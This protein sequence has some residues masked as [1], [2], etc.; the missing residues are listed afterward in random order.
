[1][2]TPKQAEARGVATVHQELS[3]CPHLTV[4]ENVYLGRA[5][6]RGGLLDYDAMAEGS[7]RML[8]AL[9]ATIDPAAVAGDL[10]LADR[11]LVEIA[12]ALVARPRLLILDEATSALDAGQAQALFA[13]LRRLRDD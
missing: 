2:L 7:R 1:G 10:S 3:L 8:A 9:G 13:A 12:K 6:T 4:A 5:P 11:Q